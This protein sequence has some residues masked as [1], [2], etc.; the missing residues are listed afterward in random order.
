M[1]LKIKSVLKSL[2]H[3]VYL[4][5]ILI[6]V[7][8]NNSS[9]SNNDN[10]SLHI[11]ICY[12]HG[13]E[14][15][16][17]QQCHSTSDTTNSIIN[18]L[19]IQFNPPNIDEFNEM[20]IDCHSS[21]SDYPIQPHNLKLEISHLSQN[22]FDCS[23]CHFEHKGKQDSLI[24]TK[25]NEC[26]KC[27][28]NKTE[29]FIEIH[30]KVES[31]STTEIHWKF[32]HSNHQNLHFDK[33]ENTFNCQDCHSI[34]DNGLMKPIEYST[35]CTTCHHHQDQFKQKTL[36]LIQIPGLDYEILMDEGINIGEWPIDAGIDLEES[37]N[38]FIFKLLSNNV[39]FIVN[40]LI[41]EE[42]E[43][44]DLSDAEDYL[45]DIGLVIWEIKKVLFSFTSSQQISKQIGITDKEEIN[46]IIESINDWFPNLKNELDEINNN[47]FP[48]TM[49][50]EDYSTVDDV[51]EQ[52]IKSAF[53]FNISYQIQNHQNPIM[54]NLLSNHF[55][56]LNEVLVNE[57]PGNCLKCHAV[58]NEI[59]D[60]KIKSDETQ[61]HKLVKTFNHENHLKENKCQDCHIET[62]D[63]YL[64]IQIETCE[65]C[66]SSEKENNCSVCHTYHPKLW[67]NFRK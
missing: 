63:S 7:S 62:E 51:V 66:H 48:E 34:S 54:V 61:P 36:K 26:I 12:Q 53:D 37:I 29:N 41:D 19:S 6:L 25:S 21:I 30:N 42:I 33:S 45:E 64:P 40:T 47:E 57:N 8:C 31:I 65:S 67:K 60:W 23:H 27:H 59:I 18:Q 11:K 22:Q 15:L 20:C 50:Y 1:N 58:K 43:L 49:E 55:Q 16:S 4:F 46:F 32:N 44:I 5:I 35:A 10:Y 14:N 24:L 13:N 56:S 38:P 9:S 17:C 2:S 39:K 3:Y 52:L 28:E